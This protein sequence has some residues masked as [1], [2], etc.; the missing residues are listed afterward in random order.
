MR[1]KIDCMVARESIAAASHRGH[2]GDA[3]GASAFPPYHPTSATGRRVVTFS[4]LFVLPIIIFA[5]A[6]RLGGVS[7]L[8]D[9]LI[10]YLP[11]RQYI[12]E[13]IRDGEFPLWNPLCAM[14]SPIAADPQAGLWYPPTYLFALL[15]PLWAYP[16]TLVLHFALAGG[17]MYRFLRASRRK[18]PAALLGALA[19]E[20]AGFL[21]AHRAHLTILEAVA[22]LPW[23]FYA[24]RRFADHGRYR[25]FALASLVLGL[26]MLVQH[27]QVSIIGVTLL[28]AWVGVV[29][30]PRRHGLAWQYPIATV[31][32]VMLAGI[33]LIPTLFYFA[34][35]VRGAPAYHLFIENSWWPGSAVLMLFPLFF[36]TRTPAFW[37]QPWWGMSHFC[38]QSAYAS[39]VVLVLAFASLALC[40]RRPAASPRYWDR[41]VIFWWLAMVA[42]LLVALGQY[43]PVA[44]GMFHVPLYRSLRVPARWILVWS[45]AL[46]VLAAATASAVLVAGEEARRIGRFLRWTALVVL[47]AMMAL[48]LIVLVVAGLRVNDLITHY[49]SDWFAPFW[50]GL[51][52]AIRPGNPA[53][54][55]PVALAT[56]TAVFVSCWAG[57]GARRWTVAVIGLML[58]DLAA[59]AS[60]VDVDLTTYKRADLEQTPAL[61]EAV[62]ELDPAPGDRL[63]VPRFAADYEK[64]IEVLWPQYNLSW[65]VATFNTYGPLWP[66]GHRLLFQFMPWGSSESILRLV[67]EPDLCRAMGLRFLAVRSG[68]EG[69][70]IETASW[71]RTGAKPATIAE[72][73]GMKAVRAGR[74]LLWPVRV[75]SPGL[76]EFRLDIEPGRDRAQRSFVRIETVDGEGISWTSSIEPADLSVGRRTM[77]FLFR[78]DVAPGEAQVRLKSERGWAMSAGWATFG[79]IAA[80]V[81]STHGEAGIGTASASAGGPY[82]L[83]RSMEGDIRLYELPGPVE[84][85]RWAGKARI[86][87]DLA[88]AVDTL[89][90]Q[91]D[92]VGL[93]AGVVV[94]WPE[95]GLPPVGGR[96]PIETRRLSAREVEIGTNSAEA[97]LLVFNTAY[98]P[99][100]GAWVDGRPAPVYRVNAVVQGVVVPPGLHTVR[101]GYCP[102]G[103]RAGG[104]WTG[105]GLLSLFLGAWATRR[106]AAS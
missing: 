69:K 71:P 53:I 85:V 24:W 72:S 25:H 43:G 65:E 19:F 14:G 67:N 32:G 103:L 31:I 47:P 42:A 70:I 1:G 95:R 76:Y 77:R 23:L 56:L 11:V 40:R 87:S 2:K 55:L 102:A 81:A 18:W 45:F 105:M 91:A 44:E 46:P 51:R 61:V 75:D 17:G 28:T 50:A 52:A 101:F 26:Q 54:W 22:W 3:E 90:N 12:G 49:P 99:G 83:R 20:F 104:I 60:R 10:Y 93:P 37:E 4:L 8:E 33:Q 66:V 84:L 106:L 73:T 59:V 100:W 34:G 30:W 36:G 97:G 74:D 94:E 68:E 16:V 86:V 80:K 15:P 27:V 58:V 13:R 88:G 35:S 79:C 98:D 62:R 57:R 6:W 82:V 38:E 92:V 39:L 41:E 7:A 96:G 29:L 64:P 63:L 5:G 89:L 48:T 9:D 21:V 78:C